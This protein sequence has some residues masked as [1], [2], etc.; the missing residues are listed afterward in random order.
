M[1]RNLLSFDKPDLNNRLLF[2]HQPIV[3]YGNTSGPS[4]LYCLPNL[5]R[6]ILLH[7]LFYFTS[8][9][10]RNGQVLHLLL[11]GFLVGVRN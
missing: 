3:P 8:F 10:R 6:C 5:R 2:S 11:C 4:Y 1:H 9:S 7:D